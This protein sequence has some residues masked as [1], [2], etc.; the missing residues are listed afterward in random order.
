MTKGG[1]AHATEL[2]AT[3]MYNST[4]TTYRY[5][6]GSAISTTIMLISLLL[7]GTSQWLANRNKS[8]Q[9]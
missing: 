4:F 1:P 9:T 7:I 2:L 5:G 8:K 3:Y 6:F